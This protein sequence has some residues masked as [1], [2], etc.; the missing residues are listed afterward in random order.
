MPFT[1]Q[2]A[3][4]LPIV[5]LTFDFAETLRTT[6][7]ERQLSPSTNTEQKELVLKMT[8]I[9]KDFSGTRALDHVDFD[10]RRGEVHALIGENGAGKSTLMNVLAGRFTDYRGS[11][12]FDGRTV[13]ITSPRQACSMGV[14]VIYQSACRLNAWET[15]RHPQ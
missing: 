4:F 11:I 1:R 10:V 12:T 13:R 6:T 5:C 14:A 8:G 2:I 7:L 3:F 9:V 15:A